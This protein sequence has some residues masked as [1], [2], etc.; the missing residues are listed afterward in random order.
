M[1]SH[2]VRISTHRDFLIGVF[3][4]VGEHS[5][6]TKVVVTLF[7]KLAVQ[8]SPGLGSNTDTIADFE[9]GAG[10]AGGCDGSDDFVA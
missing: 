2:T 1:N 10:W 8:T 3:G 6:P 4:V 7:A 5:L 9:T